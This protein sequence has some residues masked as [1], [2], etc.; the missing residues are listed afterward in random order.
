MHSVTLDGSGSPRKRA[1]SRGLSEDESL[2]NIIK[3]VRERKSR[4]Y[5]CSPVDMCSSFPHN[6]KQ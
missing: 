6:P 4:C 1:F 3:E 2:R 5:V